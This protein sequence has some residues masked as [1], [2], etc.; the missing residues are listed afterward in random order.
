MT[1][2]QFLSLL[3]QIGFLIVAIMGNKK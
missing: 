2:Y 3:I 1:T